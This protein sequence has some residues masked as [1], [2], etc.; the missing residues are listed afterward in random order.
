MT[1]DKQQSWVS[2]YH[3]ALLEVDYEKLSER[4]KLTE[5]AIRARLATLPPPD[6]TEL[7]AIH[8]AR[9]NLRVLQ[10]ELETHQ[11]STTKRIRHA[12]SEINGEFVVFV[13]ADRRY[14]EVTD[15]V[16][17]LLGYSREELLT[18]TIDEISAPELRSQVPETFRQYIAEGG[19]EGQY[20][21]LSK[22]G[23]RIPIRYQAKV[24]PDGCRVAR[25][26]PLEP[27]S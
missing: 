27:S 15:G 6:A 13:N 22:D 16:C 14:V 10:R 8:D 3:S 5:E 2:L 17:R 24:Y 11:L 12:H 18:K 7:S 20:S 23:R 25:W 9:Q 21:V 26:E 19:L 1:A 4:L